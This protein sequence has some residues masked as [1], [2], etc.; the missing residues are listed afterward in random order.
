MRALEV[1]SPVTSIGN[2]LRGAG[3][4]LLRRGAIHPSAIRRL[5]YMAEGVMLGVP[6]IR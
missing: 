4:R 2:P 1:R 6:V 3:R 5:T